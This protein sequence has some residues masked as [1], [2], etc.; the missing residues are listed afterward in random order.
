MSASVV[1]LASLPSQI[2]SGLSSDRGIAFEMSDLIY[3]FGTGST[4]TG[5]QR[6]QQEIGL[7]LLREGKAHFVL[8]DNHLQK[9]R[10]LPRQW[11]SDLISAA[12]SFGAGAKTWPD[13]YH[14]FYSKVQSFPLKQFE[15]GQWLL[16]V[17]ASW[18]FPGYFTQI[19]QLRR[20][21]IHAAFFLHD[22]IPMRHP[23][24]F[25]D[26][27]TIE[28]SYWL[29]QIRGTADLVICNSECTRGDYL[30]LVRPHSVDAVKTCPLDGSWFGDVE[31]SEGDIGAEELLS[32]CG[33][34]E[35]G[36]VLSVGTIEPRKNHIA[37]VHVWDKLRQTHAAS[38]PKLICVGRIGWKSDAVIAQ[39][40]AFGLL[41]NH[42]F[43][44][45]AV[46]DEVLAALYK[47]CLFTAY[48]SYY[49][50][51]GLPI[52]ESL[53]AGKACIA[54]KNSSL[55]EAGCG[56]VTHIDERSETE[57]Y[58][59]V[60]AFLDEPQFLEAAA[61]QIRLRYRPNS[62][63]TIADKLIETVLAVPA[64][65]QSDQFQTLE[66][67]SLHLFG[68]P[69]PLVAFDETGGAESFCLG[70]SWHRPEDWGI[71]TSKESSEL[72]FKILKSCQQPTVFLGVVAPPGGAKISLSLNGKHLRDFPEFVG[73]KTIRIQI[74]EELL[75]GGGQYA[76]IRIK[77]AASRVQ[78]MQELKDSGDHRTL[79]AGFLFVAAFDRGSVHERIEFLELV[80][81]DELC[82]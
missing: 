45:G 79:G 44:P 2:E 6:V 23:S 67:N 5:I 48:V 77:I 54:G 31:S 15:A 24:Y 50:G 28:H 38:L 30:E 36:F 22:C 10:M 32:D 33:G 9:W 20:R 80:M 64:N 1:N 62:W 35:E 8:Y 18:S 34:A 12:R 53:Q 25:E 29:G 72:G 61:A 13:I 7:S 21:G 42:V 82:K 46:S 11:L 58:G 14:E 56:L 55:G 27:H 81:T 49:E 69:K 43:F 40:R 16:N 71:W 52:S 39:A 70:Q 41:N 57:I 60:R 26:R 63:S 74:P 59:A 17:G 78:R 68:R 76:P 19:R 47:R 73:K 66:M 75:E 65:R 4:P 37:L 3:Y 51:W